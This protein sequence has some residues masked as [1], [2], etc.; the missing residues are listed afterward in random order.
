MATQKIVSGNAQKLKDSGTVLQ[1]GALGGSSRITNGLGIATVGYHSGTHGSAIPA[2]L[3]D[4]TI[5]ANTAGDTEPA[6]GRSKNPTYK[7]LAAG[8]FG[9]MGKGKYVAMKLA[10][11]LSG[12]A[13]TTL[14]T[15]AADFGNRRTLHGIKSIRTSFLRI[16]TWTGARDGGPAYTKTYS[17]K[18]PSQNDY[19]PDHEVTVTRALPGELTYMYGNNTPTNAD[20]P[21]RTA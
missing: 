19:R 20:Y 5:A 8:T 18:T 7:P 9:Y 11:T 6:T 10:E 1:P 15:G 17:N 16:W 21:A 2:A 4:A 12:V 3:S 13:N 14:F